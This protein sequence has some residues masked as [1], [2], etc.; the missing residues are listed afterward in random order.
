MKPRYLG[1][2]PTP[3]ESSQKHSICYPSEHFYLLSA[4]QICPLHSIL[5]L[6]AL[7]SPPLISVS[8]SVLTSCVLHA[9]AALLTAGEAQGWSIPQVLHP[10]SSP[11][12]TTQVKEV[13]FHNRQD[14]TVHWDHPTALRPS[15]STTSGDEQKQ[16][17][18]PYSLQTSTASPLHLP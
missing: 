3:P 16:K 10:C 12:A 11:P 1:M 18:N 9:A 8:A 2:I 14:C 13:P 6:A 4:S 7:P 17:S 15:T 5:V